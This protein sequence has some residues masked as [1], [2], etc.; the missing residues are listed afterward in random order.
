MRSGGDG[1]GDLDQVGVHRRRVDEGQ[2]QPRSDAAGRADCAKQICPLIAGVAGRA[3][4]CAASGPDAG[5]GSLPAHA[6]FILEP[7]LQ[8][9][10][11]CPRGDRGGCRCGEVFLNVS[12]AWRSDFGCC[13]RTDS[14]RNP[15][16]ANCLPTLRS[17]NSTPNSAAMRCCKSRCRQRTTPLRDGSGPAST[18]GRKRGHL[19]GSQPPGAVRHRP[20]LQPVQPLGIGAMHPVPQ[21]LAVHPADHRRRRTVNAPQHQRDCQHPPRCPRILRLA[22]RR[23]QL[24]SRQVQPRDHNPCHACF[25]PMSAH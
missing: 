22:R 1:A 4:P 23:A 2:D 14:R 20:V 9:L 24:R 10:V 5:E 19:L 16:A 3:G 8:R 11:P 17:C 7:Y 12:C 6:R 15:S 25:P 21:R 18:Q 13:G